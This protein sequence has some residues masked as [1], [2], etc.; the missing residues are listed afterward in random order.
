MALLEVGNLTK[1]LS[2]LI[3]YDAIDQESIHLDDRVTLSNEA[4]ALN[5]NYELSNIPLRQ[6]LDY[7]VAEL[8]EAVEIGSANGALLAL[9]EH[10]ASS[11]EAFQDLMQAKVQSILVDSDKIDAQ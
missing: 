2:L 3:I 11:K 6:D 9:A 5:Q 10:T 4:Y 7:S 8:L 1:L